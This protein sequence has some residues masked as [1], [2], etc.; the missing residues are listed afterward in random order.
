MPLIQSSAPDPTDILLKQALHIV[1]TE[2]ILREPSV[3]GLEALRL[4]MMLTSSEAA[5][6]YKHGNNYRSFQSTYVEHFRI[7]SEE[8]GRLSPQQKASFFLSHIVNDS[9]ASAMSGQIPAF[10]EEDI[11]NYAQFSRT[12]TTTLIRNIVTA[13]WVIE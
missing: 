7:L 11:E 5:S 12:D 13:V 10:T 1:D 3:R 8:E 2:G 6:Q 4:L 9:F